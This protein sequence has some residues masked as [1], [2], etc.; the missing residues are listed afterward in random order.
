VEPVPTVSLA[1]GVGMP[2]IGFGTSPMTDDEAELGV[3]AALAAGYR[4]IDTAE[5]YGNEAGVGRA[6]RRSGIPR[7]QVF[8]STKFNVPWHSVDGPRRA[9]ARSTEL[10]GLDR[11]D[12]LLIH[13][14]NPDRGRFVDAWRGLLAVLDEGTARAVGVSNFKPAHL[15]RLLDETGAAPHVNQIQLDPTLARSGERRFH[16]EHGIRTMSWSPLGG[17]GASVLR[18]PEVVEIAERLRR[19]PAQVVLR[20]HVQQGLVP[21][22]RTSRPE[23]MAENLDVFGFELPDDDLRALGS[24]DGTGEAPYDSDVVGH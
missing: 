5:Q 10:L 21:V 2:A 7:D 22:P 19:T 4:L 1:N 9:A 6:I 11:L 20:W 8:V 24:L 17:T 23:R 12:L 3:T 15:R 13:W 18:R 16:D 14:P